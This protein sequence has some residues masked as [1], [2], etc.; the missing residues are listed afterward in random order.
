MGEEG[1][2]AVLQQGHPEDCDLHAWNLALCCRVWVGAVSLL[3]GSEPHM[4]DDFMSL[5][6]E[7]WQAV[8]GPLGLAKPVRSMAFQVLQT[9]LH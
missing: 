5:G 7:T 4:A 3:D 1:G 6:R 2:W 8:F 9:H